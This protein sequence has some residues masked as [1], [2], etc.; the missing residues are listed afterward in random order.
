MLSAGGSKGLQM[1]MGRSN[2]HL[3]FL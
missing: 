2:N 1:G 3:Q